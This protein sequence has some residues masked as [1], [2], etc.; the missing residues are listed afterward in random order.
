MLI[1]APQTP[2]TG[3]FV[4]G[5]VGHHLCSGDSMKQLFIY[6]TSILLI[7]PALNAQAQRVTDGNYRTVAHIKSDGT[8]QDDSYR[9]I[10]HIKSD[11]TVQ[12]ANYRTVGHLRSDGTVQ[13]SNYRTVG[14]IKSDGTVQDGNYRTV[15][16]IKDDGTVQDAN[17]RTIGHADGIPKA[18]VAWYF[19]F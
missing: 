12:D 6:L 2:L 5:M 14:H 16:H 10:G 11:G 4:Y 1:S 3:R 18:W 19:F 13:D 7:L 8:I 15:G 17:Y 9:T